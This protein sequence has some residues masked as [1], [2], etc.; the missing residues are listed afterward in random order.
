M[1]IKIIAKSVGRFLSMFFLGL[2]MSLTASSLMD[3]YYFFVRLKYSSGQDS[4]RLWLIGGVVLGI[5][6]GIGTSILAIKRTLQP[7]NLQLYTLIFLRFLATVLLTIG[8]VLMFWNYYKFD[9]FRL[10][11][12]GPT[13]LMVGLMVA[14]W[15][16]SSKIST[17]LNNKP[18]N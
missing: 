10:K 16:L 9:Y 5:L 7:Q 14:L 12:A 17:H 18:E 8:F 3:I 15:D 6:L 4:L 2:A 13:G 1:H 11:D